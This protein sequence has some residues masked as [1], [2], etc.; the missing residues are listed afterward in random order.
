M[1][2]PK[3]MATLSHDNIYAY[4]P[5]KCFY[6]SPFDINGKWYL[7]LG[8]L[9]LIELSL[10]LIPLFACLCA[11]S[12]SIYILHLINLSPFVINGKGICSSGVAPPN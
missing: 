1:A 4:T 11:L 10:G 7:P 9:P 8:L 2:T 5:H 6:L 12:P 3:L